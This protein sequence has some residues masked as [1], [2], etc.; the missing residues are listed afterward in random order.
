MDTYKSKEISARQQ[1]AAEKENLEKKTEI[2]M[3]STD[4]CS[5]VRKSG[6]LPG[7]RS[8]A[9]RSVVVA[10]MALTLLPIGEFLVPDSA[11]RRRSGDGSHASRHAGW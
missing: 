9:A 11:G 10:V 6:L 1:P 2:E 8:Q 3:V 5:R 4:R 7:A